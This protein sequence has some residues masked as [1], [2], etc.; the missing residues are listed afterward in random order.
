MTVTQAAREGLSGGGRAPEAGDG[1]DGLPVSSSLQHGAHGGLAEQHI[2]PYLPLAL[3]RH[4]NVL[5]GP[6]VQIGSKWIFVSSMGSPEWDPC[7]L[8]F[9]TNPLPL[10]VP[11]SL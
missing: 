4:W 3:R 7:P 8:P 5:A 1:Q 9:P 10:D 11:L 2:F 6:S